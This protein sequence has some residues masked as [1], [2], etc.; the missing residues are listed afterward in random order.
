[1]SFHIDLVRNLGSMKGR[2]TKN[3]YFC[4][5]V[6]KMNLHLN[7]YYAEKFRKT[8]GIEIQSQHWGGNRQLSM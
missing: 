4:D 2:N 7:K 3:Y 6:S 5:N 1:M 8:N